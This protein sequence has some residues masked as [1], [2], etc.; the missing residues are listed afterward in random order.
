MA[1]SEGPR[2][3]ASRSRNGEME[4][5]VLLGKSDLLLS[6]LTHEL[7]P[8]LTPGSAVVI[9]CWN[10]RL[11]NP[12]LN[13]TLKSRGSLESGVWSLESGVWSLESGVW[14]LESGVW[15]L[16]DGPMKCASARLGHESAD[17]PIMRRG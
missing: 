3:A 10:L 1:S 13:L 14:S 2:R 16:D 7:T 9:C 12:T 6:G 5:A 4:S 17:Q 15:T 8:A 11:M